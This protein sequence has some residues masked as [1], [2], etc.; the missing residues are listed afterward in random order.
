M[1]WQQFRDWIKEQ[2][3]RKLCREVLLERL[4]HFREPNDELSKSIHNWLSKNHPKI[5]KEYCKET[6]KKAFK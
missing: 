1:G 3:V 2:P 5:L 6:I 4:D